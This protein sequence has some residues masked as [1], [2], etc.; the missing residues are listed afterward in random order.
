MNL[1]EGTVARE[2]GAPVFTTTEGIALPLPAGLWATTPAP[3]MVY[4]IPPAHLAL[5]LTDRFPTRE[6]VVDPTGAENPELVKDG[7][8]HVALIVHGRENLSQGA[9]S[10]TSPPPN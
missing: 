7:S 6:S 10:A 5:H 1:L 2:N 9:P 8:V 4:G 3:D